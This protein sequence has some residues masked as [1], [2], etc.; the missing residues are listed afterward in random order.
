MNRLQK[1]KR[2]ARGLG[3][4][5]AFLIVFYV[6]VRMGQPTSGAAPQTD[7]TAIGGDHSQHE[8]AVL[9]TCSMHPQIQLPEPGQCPICGM[10]LI[11]LTTEHDENQP[12]RLAMS[13]SDQK[14]AE[15]QTSPVERKFADARIRMVG[16]ID[17]DETRVKSI[18]SYVPG[19]IDRLYIDYTGIEVKK[20][21]H[22]AEIY[23]PQLLTAQEELLEAG[24]RTGKSTGE[25]S[26]FLRE[27][28]RRAL[29]SAREKLR[30][31]GLSEGQIKG[32]EDRGTP[33]NHMQ[34]NAPIGG[35]VIR[36]FLN[37]GD[38]VQTGSHVYTVADLSRV[39]VRL[40]AYETDLPWIHFGQPVDIEA[41][42][43]PGE[44]FAGIVAFIDPVLDPKTRTVNVR[45]NVENPNG[46]LKPGIFVRGT[47]HSRV[48]KAGKVMDPGLAGKWISPMHPEIVRDAPGPCPICG[49]ALLKAEDLGYVSADDESAKPLVVPASAVMK[50]G[51]RAIVYVAVPGAERPTYEGREIVLGP[52]AGSFYVV[53]SGLEE[54]E[55]V[56]TH[57][58]FNIDSALQIRAKPSMLSMEGESP[59]E[60]GDI[61]TFLLAL[62]PI[63]DAYLNTQTHLARDESKEAQEAFAHVRHRVEAV[64]MT[65]LEGEAHDAWMHASRMLSRASEEMS[66]STN[67]DEV[68]RAFE[69]ASVAV[70]E[71]E[72][73][74][75]HAGDESHAEI[76]CPMAFD[77]GASWIQRTRVVM[78]PYFGPGML[79]CGNV[80]NEYAPRTSRG[81]A[82]AGGLQH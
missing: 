28:D 47:V 5:A 14:L 45:V 11:P 38:Y 27:S 8:Q 52:R 24:R 58:N 31:Y 26:D 68:R 30:L 76:R 57:G 44:H 53:E 49:M 75:G 61:G 20:G 46:R 63:Y 7:A 32:I 56:V 73:R 55:Q 59:E 2:I 50:T 64:D 60:G 40:D 34:I 1:L 62:A 80:V 70:I 29:D 81:P 6:G 17:Y 21:D 10:N 54:G 35:I 23:S 51:R 48:A 78:N 79:T 19:R 82:A 72:R 77:G 74:F 22:L 3:L 13:P 36:K 18:S 42:A 43:Y 12:R 39:W 65:L 25:R 69:S 4:L 41:E 15:I 67:I 16:K 66:A 37:E 71:L 9:W 33:E